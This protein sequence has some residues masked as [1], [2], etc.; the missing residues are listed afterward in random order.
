MSRI[1]QLIAEHCPDGVPFLKVSEVSFKSS[2]IKWSQVGVEKYRYIDLSSVDR[3]TRVIGDAA[4]IN[5]DNAPSRAQQIV[6]FGDVIFAT[7]RPAQMRWTVI[8]VEFDGQIA[9]TGYCVIRPNTEFI[10]TNFLAHLLDS[11]RFR[12][13]IELNQVPGN[14][15]SIPDN[16]VRS[17]EIPVPP[18]AIQ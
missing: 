4:E 17:F 1:D 7:T 15:P 9:S 5:A 6:Q 16:L 3:S 11:D 2:N 14:Y 13:Y 8:P 12:R 18:M 10:L